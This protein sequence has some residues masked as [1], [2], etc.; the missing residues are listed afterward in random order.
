MAQGGKQDGAGRP[1]G[2]R[3]LWSREI[4]DK[5]AAS[6][7]LPHEFLLAVAR[8][9]RIP[10]PAD[11]ADAFHV[12]TIEQRLE[13]AKAAAPYFAARLAAIEHSGDGDGAILLVSK[14]QRDA[15]VA[16]A[17]RADH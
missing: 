1:E 6:G 13:A 17:M 4:A 15:A 10:M 14:A 11:G 9:E 12:P 2:A 3:N 7:L 8:G 16:A 5:A